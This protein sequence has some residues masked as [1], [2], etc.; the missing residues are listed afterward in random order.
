MSEDVWKQPGRRP[1][2]REGA[3]EARS[4]DQGR[5]V[6]ALIR[7]AAVGLPEFDDPLFGAAFDRFADA[8]VVL[9]G[10]ASHGTS[11]FYRARAAITRRLIEQHGFTIVAVEADWP[12]A[13]VIDRHVRHRGRDGVARPFSRFPTWM[14]M[15]REVRA[16]SE[17]LAD[18]NRL[19]PMERRAGFFGLDLYNLSASMRAVIDYL[20]REDPEA[21][22]VARARYGCLTPWSREPADYGRLALTRG[23][24][25]CEAGVVAMLREML[26]GELARVGDGGDDYLDAAM[27]AHLVQN[28]EAYYRAM[29]YGSAESWNLR[30]THMFETLEGLLA[31]HG[32]DA[33]A[34]VWAHNSHIG[35]ARATDM[36]KERGE[37]NLGQLCRQRFGEAAALIGFGTHTGTVACASD[38]DEPMEVKR[39]LPSREDSYERLWRRAERPRALVDLR[40][41]GPLRRALTAP[42]LE[43]MIGVIYRPETERWSHYV[44]CEL[45]EQFDGYVWFE[46]T[47]AVTPLPVAEAPVQ[48]GA[49]ETWPF[50][51]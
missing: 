42:R 29:Y 26:E 38:W 28:A 50:G 10:E 31:H 33:R 8:R 1:A 6:V 9:L 3:A 35:D 14:W 4:F 47:S 16:F 37:L 49:E 24:A 34:V 23:Y 46:E 51:L 17:W 32:P 39:V 45:P 20:D 19:R 40:G 36:G 11:E 21:A 13:S 22:A 5:D 41:E 27:N 12:D 18:H 2:P 48:P 43:R 25:P 44:E 7:E 30:D 15:N